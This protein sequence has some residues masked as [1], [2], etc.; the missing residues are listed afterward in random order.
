LELLSALDGEMVDYDILYTAYAYFAQSDGQAGNFDCL[1]SVYEATLTHPDA[2]EGDIL[3]QLIR[4][5]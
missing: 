1:R 2:P 4:G 5:E 3:A